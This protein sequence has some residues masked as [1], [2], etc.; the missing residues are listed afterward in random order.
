MAIRVSGHPSSDRAAS[1]TLPA[2]PGLLKDAAGA[3]RRLYGERMVRA[4]LFGSQ[5]RGDAEPESDVDILVVLNRLESQASEIERTS[6]L[7]ADLSIRARTTVSFVFVTAGYWA[8][9]DTPFL[10]TVR[11]DARPL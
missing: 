1:S 3:L 5:A 7:R 10:T 6:F 11:P 9:A 4:Y 8:T 2:L